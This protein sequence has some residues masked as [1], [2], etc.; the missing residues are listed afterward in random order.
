MVGVAE[1]AAELGVSP[2]RVRQML[3]DGAI[4]GERVGRAWVIDAGRLREARGRRREV[5]RP[6]SSNS[7]WAVL[8]LAD[9]ESPDLSP[10]QRSRARKR[11]AHGLDRVA[12]R[13]GARAK[14]RRFYAHPG[15]LDR[16]ASASQVVRSGISAAGEHGVDLVAAAGFEGYVRAGDLDGIVSRFGLDDEAARPNVLLRVVDDGVWPFQAGQCSPGSAVVAVDLAESDEPR[17]RRA[18]VELLEGM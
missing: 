16:L 4:V 10:V 12:G 6:W 8:M 17:S 5:G 15:V 9:G 1:A 2:R 13:L 7:A 14:Q 18:G 3:A 11:L